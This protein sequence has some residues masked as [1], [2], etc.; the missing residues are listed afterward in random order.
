MQRRK[1]KAAE[2]NETIIGDLDNRICNLEHDR[3][4]SSDDEQI[5]IWKEMREKRRCMAVDHEKWVLDGE[6]IA[7]LDNRS[8][9]PQPLPGEIASGEPAEEPHDDTGRDNHAEPPS[10][11]A[12]PRSSESPQPRPGDHATEGA[13][14]GPHDGQ[15]D[16]LAE[17][18]ADFNDWEMEGF[19]WPAKTATDD[20]DA[21]AVPVK[22]EAKEAVDPLTAA[23]RRRTAAAGVSPR[24][25]RQTLNVTLGVL[26]PRRLLK[27]HRHLAW[28][29]SHRHLVWRLM[30][31]LPPPP[32]TPPTCL[33]NGSKR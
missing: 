33:H 2:A 18:R 19:E 11:D 13:D 9:S 14:A 22:R 23:K 24:A 12:A 20:Q 5:S 3:Q 32:P 4:D 16:R 29:T 26:C 25:L 15:P 28:M 6:P 7:E 30:R 10:H 21:D 27:G 1:R 31:A 8:G 17:D